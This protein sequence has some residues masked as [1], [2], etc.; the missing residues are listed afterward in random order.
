[1]SATLLAS[2]M[3]PANT[4]AVGSTR[5]RWAGRILTG[6]AVLFLVFD[7]SI[8]PLASDAASAAPLTSAG[9]RTTCSPWG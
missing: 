5:A 8:K 3:L 4:A 2:A 6:I 9:R 1:M 7:L